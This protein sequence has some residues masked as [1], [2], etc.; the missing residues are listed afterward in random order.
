MK[1]S[2]GMIAAALSLWVGSGIFGIILT[3]GWVLNVVKLCYCDFEAPYRAE[4]VRAVGIA[5]PPVGGF[6]GWMALEDGDDTVR[7]LADR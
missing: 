7:N 4:G 2:K 3:I 6:V 1:N 5:V